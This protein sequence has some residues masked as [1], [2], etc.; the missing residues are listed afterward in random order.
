MST[1]LSAQRIETLQAKFEDSNPQ[2]V[3]KWA[4]DTYGD[5]FVVVTS[6]QP[7]GIVTVH[8]LSEIA[9][10]TSVYT[11]DTGLLFDET[12]TLINQLEAQ[13]KLKLTRIT[14]E[15]SVQQQAEKHGDELWKRDPDDCCNRRKT[16]PL[17][18]ALKG[19][20][21]W[22][23][24]L[25]RDQ[26]EKRAN[27]PIISWDSRYNMIKLCPFA[28]WTEAMI[29]TYIHAYEL[30]Y[31]DLHDKGYPTI[32]CYPCTKTVL[33]G[34]DPRSGRWSNHTKTECGIHFDT[35]HSTEKDQENNE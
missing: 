8:M 4:S 17:R 25:R 35:T 9:P 20:S 24:G 3:L 21:A 5:Q 34:E 27:T 32:G 2:A 6:F 13:L 12:Y 30:P 28:T 7:T 19:F 16:I 33:D 18:H 31:N 15:L 23:T 26:S 11:L 29:W 1:P 14:A 22:A 10:K